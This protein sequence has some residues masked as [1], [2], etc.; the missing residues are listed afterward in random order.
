MQEAVAVAVTSRRSKTPLTVWA[1]ALCLF[2]C[3]SL[4]FA[5]VLPEERSDAMYHRYDGGGMV[6][7][8]PSILIRKNFKDR[9]SASYNYYVDTVSSASIDVITRGASEYSEER[10]EHSVDLTLLE[11]KS[12]LNVGFTTSKENDYEAKN[13]R[14]DYSQSFFGDMTTLS[15]GFSLGDDDITS[16][17]DDPAVSDDDVN[18]SLERRNYRI[19]IAQI[20]SRR[21]ILNINFE[22]IAD[23]GYLQNPYRF[24]LFAIIDP[25]TNKVIYDDTPKE[26]Y[27]STRNSDAYS[28][29]AAYHFKGPYAGKF[30]LGY[31]EDSWGIEGYNFDIGFSYKFKQ[32]WIVDLKYRWYEQNQA[33]FYSHVF[34]DSNLDKQLIGSL[35]GQNS[36]GDINQNFRGRDKELSSFST[37]SIGLGASYEWK[38]NGFFDKFKFSTHVDFMEFNYDNFYEVLDKSKAGGEPLY[39]FDAYALRVFVSAW[40]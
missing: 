19:G 13:Y 11:K 1:L 16:S 25:N 8:G 12:L 17:E 31:F 29:K 9:V 5:A 6:I 30:K 15:M 32:R 37:Q 22:S 23:E 24:I 33:D 21:L 14:I 2:V 4:S 3:S 20:I 10:K 7:D 35:L 26:N 38:N 18:E 34:V 36:V 27:P 39:S 28:I 40:Y